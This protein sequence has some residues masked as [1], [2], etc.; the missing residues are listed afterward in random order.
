MPDLL[1]PIEADLDPRDYTLVL[2]LD[3]TLVHYEPSRRS[4]LLRPGCLMFLEAM[5]KH[6]EVVIFTASIQRLA[7]IILNKMDPKGELIKHRLYR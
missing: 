5:A 7:D 2:D 1:P 6:Y 3:Q 4:Y